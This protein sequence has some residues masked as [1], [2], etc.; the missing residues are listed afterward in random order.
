VSRREQYPVGLVA[1]R[2]RPPDSGL[3]L[4]ARDFARRRGA[5][6]EGLAAAIADT[7]VGPEHADDV[8]VLCLGL[9]SE[10]RMQRS[11]GADPMQIALL[12]G[13]LRNWLAANGV[14]DES[15]EAILLACS[16]A[17]A[18]AIEHGYRDDPF[19]T[20][21]VS[22]TVSAQ[23]VE[24]RVA[25]RGTWRP[26]RIDVARG[27]GLQLIRQVMDQVGF[28]RGEGTTVTMRRTRKEAR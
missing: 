10:E 6:I 27:R 19:G 14:D 5:P 13:D 21:E 4:L 1:R 17:V 25:D 3:E 28:E 23:A 9:G 2:G 20:V 16:E 15:A 7:L 24:I 12:R 22:A 18:N 11:I 26:A 8:C